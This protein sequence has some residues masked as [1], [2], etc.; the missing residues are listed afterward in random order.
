[1]EPVDDA[2]LRRDDRRRERRRLARAQL[3]ARRLD[4]FLHAEELGDAAPALDAEAAPAL[5][6]LFARGE[7]ILQR[8]TATL[9]EVPT[10]R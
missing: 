8:R 1:M 6:L 3:A 7:H 5:T 4:R 10:R 2:G 9:I